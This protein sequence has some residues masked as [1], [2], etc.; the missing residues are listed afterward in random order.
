MILYK[1][2][3]PAKAREC[4]IDNDSIW[5]TP[6]VYL[7]DVLEFQVRREAMDEV[8]ARKMF[9]GFQRIKPST[10]EFED[11]WERVSSKEFVEKEP[12]D[13]QDN[14][15]KV[16]GVASFTS[17]PLNELMWSHYAENRGVA[18][19]Y[20]AS[21]ETLMDDMAARQLP[22]GYALRVGYGNSYPVIRKDFSNA[23][24]ALAWKRDAWSYE[25]EW[26]VIGSLQDA[27][28]IR[29]G[30][31]TFYGLPASRDRVAHV[32]FGINTER[33]FEEALLAWLGTSSAQVQKVG[34]DPSNQSFVLIDYPQT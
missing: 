9:E 17:E 30:D 15:S 26:R 31:K 5:L 6:P 23:V 4:L 22:C 18:I 2:L 29:F 21:D 8:E 7:N 14:L 16:L 19:G 34:I 24:R 10:L 11:Y 12:G 27:R 20:E 25:R 28:P 32:V 3:A 33:V 1:Y 13:M